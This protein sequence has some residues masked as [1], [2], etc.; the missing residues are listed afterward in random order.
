MPKSIQELDFPE[1]SFDAVIM[2]EVLEHLNE[3]D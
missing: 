2:I 1:N 3:K